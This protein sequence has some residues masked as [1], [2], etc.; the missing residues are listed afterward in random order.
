MDGDTTFRSLTTGVLP[1]A[2]KTESRIPLLCAIIFSPRPLITMSRRSLRF[3]NALQQDPHWHS[4]RSDVPALR[5]CACRGR[6]EFIPT[7]S[8]APPERLR[9]DMCFGFLRGF[10]CG[11]YACCE[12]LL[13]LPA[14]SRQNAQLAHQ[15]HINVHRLLVPHQ[16]HIPVR[17]LRTRPVSLQTSVSSPVMAFHSR[18]FSKIVSLKYF[19]TMGDR[20]SA[21][22]L[23]CVSS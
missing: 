11:R 4:P 19:Q 18:H 16:V 10:F 14:Q 12:F 13:S 22:A 7:V 17:S 1:I 20:A 3:G 21:S 8:G 9:R 6:A 5:P 15:Q 2:C 23:F